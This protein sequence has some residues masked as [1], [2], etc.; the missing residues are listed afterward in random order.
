MPTQLS[1]TQYLLGHAT[2]KRPPFYL[3]YTTLWAHWIVSSALAILSVEQDT[4]TV[5]SSLAP[6]SLA[7]GLTVYGFF[8]R[9]PILLVNVLCY[10][11]TLWCL[12]EY[13]QVAWG[14]FI[15]SAITG[16]TSCHVVISSEYTQYKR[17]V[18]IHKTGAK[19]LLATC[20]TSSAIL[21]LFAL[22]VGVLY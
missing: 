19:T 5:L 16:L 3:A 12:M 2:S 11:S 10:A 13:S 20:L 15:F 8:A 6:A 1:F 21:L 18:G 7:L 4:L 14:L 9:Q 17:E 22:A